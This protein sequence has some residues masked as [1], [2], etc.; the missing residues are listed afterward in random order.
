MSHKMTSTS[1][2]MKLSSFAAGGK[3]SGKAGQSSVT[4]LSPENEN[5]TG[6]VN[7]PIIRTKD[8]P[9]QLPLYAAALLRSSED[10]LAA[11]DLDNVQLE[12]ETL[13]SSVALRYRILKS[14]YDSLEKDDKN[15]EK[16]S[17]HSL[18]VSG[19]VMEKQPASPATSITTCG[20]RKRD[21]TA[22]VRKPKHG[23]VKQTK[24]LHNKNSP[25]APHTDDSMEYIPSS[26]HGLHGP[27]REHLQKVALP[28]NDTPNKFWLSVE[29]YCMPLTNEDLRLLDDLLEQYNG[30]LVPP[31]PE[32]GPHYST[33]WAA[34]DLKEIQQGSNPNTG[35]RL[36]SHNNGSTDMLKRADNLVEDC[37]TG[38]LTQRL[39]SALM[40]EQLMP[41]STDIVAENSNSSSE[42]TH[43]TAPINFRS[44]TMLRN[45]IGIEKR[46]KKELIEQGI[47]DISDF[48]NND[49]DE[50]LSEI[51][52]L[53]AELSTIAEYNGNA[54]RRLHDAASEEIKRLEIK[55]KLDLVDQEILETYKRTI[56]NKAKRKPLTSEEQQEIFRLTQEQKTLS[57][58]LNIQNHQ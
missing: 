43:A 9:K 37:I 17:K 41:N 54:L 53:I 58:Q 3:F 13:L 23:S 51:K 14:E 15:K 39:V 28:K 42:N 27:N 11:E 20:K 56:Q 1:K 19:N 33:V 5:A 52:K 35:S 36:K 29:P 30:P 21:E 45:C 26:S 12:L 44:L 31:I 2:S 24:N 49:E 48:P 50:I 55:R 47:L 10:Y 40:E 38:P 8:I 46:L 7:I 25:V 18:L 6:I 34:E 22:T 32:L 57:D 4:P 16:K